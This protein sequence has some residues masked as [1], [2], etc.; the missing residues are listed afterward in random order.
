MKKS[1]YEFLS[2]RTVATLSVIATSI[3]VIYLSSI[4]NKIWNGD[5]GVFSLQT[6]FSVEA[7]SRIL[8]TMKISGKDL[9]NHYL[10]IDILFSACCA[11]TFPSVLALMFS[12]Y[13]LILEESFKKRPS[14]IL[15]KLLFLSFFLSPLITV[16]TIVGNSFILSMIRS[17]SISPALVLAAS[18]FHTVK[19]VIL[20]AILAYLI[21]LLILRRKIIRTAYRQE[22]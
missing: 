4:D 8:G 9:L 14:G 13:K 12:Q 6:A 18:V 7:F 20:F 1:F 11:V 17:G 16:L 10:L 15:S 3:I 22:R 2:N 19:F 21:F 5:F